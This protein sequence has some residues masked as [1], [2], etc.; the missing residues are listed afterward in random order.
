[1]IINKKKITK[2]LSLFENLEVSNLSKF[3]NLVDKNIVF[4]DPFNNTIGKENFKNVFKKS[5]ENVNSPKFKVLNLVSKKEIYYVKWKMTF[6]A[7]GKNQEIVGLS[8][9]RL[10]RHGLIK[11][12]YDY[13]DSFTQFYV[14]IPI[15][16]KFFLL[17]LSFIKTKI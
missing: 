5:L 3:D 1:M 15:F 4:V 16:G 12:H 7:F 14:K 9:I 17:F 11:F 13:W 2:Y 10:N 8:E 6:K